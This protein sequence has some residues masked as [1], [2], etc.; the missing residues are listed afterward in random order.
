MLLGAAGAMGGA[1][2]CAGLVS[3]A[4]GAPAVAFSL[5]NVGEGA[6][7]IR[8][9]INDT[10]DGQGKN[11]LV[12]GIKVGVASTGASP[13]V[14]NLVA[15]AAQ[16]AADLLGVSAPVLLAEKWVIAPSASMT[17]GLPIRSN[18]WNTGNKFTNTANVLLDGSGL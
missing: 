6:T 2:A 3:C 10:S 16:V 13:T 18:V 1:A 8:N 4:A 9:L 11:V 15:N 17:K 7:G 12:D 14:Q 5:S